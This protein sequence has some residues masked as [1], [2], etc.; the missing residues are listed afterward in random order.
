ML[1]GPC[2]IW[3]FFVS[4]VVGETTQIFKIFMNGHVINF[5]LILK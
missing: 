4:T 2:M 1:G 3:N 5:E